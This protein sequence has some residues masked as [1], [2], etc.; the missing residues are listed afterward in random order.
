MKQPNIEKIAFIA[1][2]FLFFPFSTLYLHQK[3]RLTNVNL[4]FF[5]LIFLTI[6]AWMI[7][8]FKDYFDIDIFNLEHLFWLLLVSSTLSALQIL[9]DI[10]KILSV[11]GNVLFSSKVPLL[12]LY[13]LF[14]LSLP[15]IWFEF[16]KKDK[17]IDISV[18][19][20]FSLM[21]SEVANILVIPITFVISIYFYLR[22]G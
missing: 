7:S 8:N 20:L 1:L 2:S 17:N 15:L 3:G 11:K 21:S 12:I 19:S 14:Y 22:S 6:L 10:D 13:S 16:Y 4:L 5:N 9:K 18:D